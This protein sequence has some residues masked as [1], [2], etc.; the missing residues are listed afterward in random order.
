[1]PT[2]RKL[3]SGKWFIQIRRKGFPSVPVSTNTKSECEKVARTI[4]HQMDLGSHHFMPPKAGELLLRHAFERYFNCA[5]Y[6]DK[7]AT[8]RKA[9]LGKAV[10]ILK[11]LGSFSLQNLSEER[12]AKY[13]DD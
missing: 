8:T 2:A 5:T 13:R 9:E 11:H 10:R 4:E 7:R 6:N 3:P 12:I 1:M